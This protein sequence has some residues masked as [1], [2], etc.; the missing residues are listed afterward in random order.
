MLKISVFLIIMFFPLAARASSPEEIMKKSQA[1]FLYQGRDFKARVLMRLTAKSG[2]ERTRELTMLRKNYGEPGGDQ[3]YF[4]Y[5]FKPSDVKDMTFMVYKYPQRDDDRWLFVPAL[6]MVRRIAAE[7]KRS[8][9]VGSDFTYEDVSG[10]DIEDDLHEF[11]KIEEGAKGP[12]AEKDCHKVRSTPK[13]GN[14]VYAYRLSWIDKSSNLPLMEEYYD[15]KETL[16][17]VFIADEIKEIK[18]FPTITRRT[19]KN[20]QSGHSTEAIF[21]NVDYNIGLE[22]TIFSERHLREPSKKRIE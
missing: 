8:S 19:M 18:G 5:F 7:D 16:I 10:R 21:T 9:F 4:M 13:S 1:A 22:D 15:K 20:M 12:C 2:S 6:N 14:E 17:R 3:R 11:L